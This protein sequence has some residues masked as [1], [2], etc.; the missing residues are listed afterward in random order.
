MPKI[1]PEMVEIGRPARLEPALRRTAAWNANRSC[2]QMLN[3]MID[4]RFPH[5]LS[6]GDVQELREAFF[7]ETAFL[8]DITAFRGLAEEPTQSVCNAFAALL[9]SDTV[10]NVND[11]HEPWADWYTVH[12]GDGQIYQ[13][14][15]SSHAE[16]V[17]PN[18]NQTLAETFFR[19]HALLKR[20]H[21]IT[22][23]FVE[24]P[25]STYI[26]DIMPKAIQ[27]SLEGA[28][29]YTTATHER[30]WLL[31]T[32][33]Y[34]VYR[35]RLSDLLGI[36]DKTLSNYEKDGKTPKGTF[37]PSPLNPNDKHNKKYYDPL[38]VLEALTA[39]PPAEKFGK[40]MAVADIIT[41]LMNNKL[42]SK[43]TPKPPKEPKKQKKLTEEEEIELEKAAIGWKREFP[44]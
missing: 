11:G 25:V 18:K 44:T 40:R 31:V 24:D 41:M 39:L 2:C 36:S 34:V 4:E 26:M 35:H 7:E 33:Q 21:T 13:L 38:K 37:W 19:A 28:L 30:P 5:R 1:Y 23:E 9:D 22:H 20:I 10:H 27:F 6:S 8:F 43:L 3:A 42:A 32:E 16:A 14:F 15:D 17:N 12:F 29:D